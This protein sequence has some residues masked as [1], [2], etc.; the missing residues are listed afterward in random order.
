MSKQV[1][2]VM[3]VTHTF[4][5]HNIIKAFFSE[6]KANKYLEELN[7]DIALNRA[8]VG[9]LDQRLASLNEFLAH[10]A[11]MSFLT[12][13]DVYEF[14]NGFNNKTVENLNKM[15]GKEEVKQTFIQGYLD[16]DIVHHDDIAYYMQTVE[17]V[18]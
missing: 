4:E 12:A 6:E 2:V 1:Y 10:S 17:L 11:N 7:N 16:R 18:E 13:D 15:E 14:V 9:Y 5:S 8:M 3:A